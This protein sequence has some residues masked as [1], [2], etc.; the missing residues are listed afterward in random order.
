MKMLISYGLLAGFFVLVVAV[1]ERTCKREQNFTDYAVAGRSFGP[2]FQTM[3]FLN[4]W[5]PGTIFIAFAGMAASSGVIGYYLIAYSLLALLLM[6][7]MAE[8]VFNW[9]TRFNLR[10]QADLVGMRY[11]ARSVRLIAA[12]IGIVSSFPWL[13]LGFQSL[14]LVF[15]YLSFGQVSVVG[16]IFIGIG[17]LAV[18]QIWTVRFGMRG[19]VISDMVQGLFAYV[20]G[21]LIALG[22]LVKLWLSGHDLNRLP[23]SLFS[24][25]G[26]GSELGPLYYMSI[27]LTGALGAW[28]WPDIFV[29]LFT[30][31]SV[32][33]IQQSVVRSAPLLYVFA[34]ILLSMAL[35]ANSVP[36]VA[37][38]P[39]QVWF[40]LASGA[41]VM[42][43]SLAGIAVLAAT[44]GNINAG[45]SAVGIQLTQDI[46]F[47]NK[48]VSDWQVTRVAKLAIAVV[49]A[50]GMSGALLTVNM[51]SGLI[52]LAL[53]SYQGIV[54]LA[55]ALY[56][57]LFW[58]R[59]NAAGAV[60]GMVS[61]FVAAA[62]LQ[63]YYPVSI[64]ALWG[65]SSGMVGMMI[66]SVVYI[67]LAYALPVSRQEAER[68][69]L[70]FSRLQ[71][72]ETRLADETAAT[73]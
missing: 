55:P 33:T 29:R 50:L 22:L 5:L 62:V 31:N 46:I 41:G 53:I 54:Q 7:Y 63:W 49:A 16:G 39:D 57:G 14:G 36:A 70:L 65:L 13:V 20:G 72:D 10:T 60:G 52:T 11:N 3:A 64:G 28:C 66:N 42:V 9:G 71:T 12:V 35:L 59:G 8:R 47:L 2:W 23:A 43:L 58:R 18:R 21:A 32:R 67:A 61:G 34:F 1:L 6:F 30:A 37:Q 17:V 45:T 40:I 44:M 48:R 38:L 19:I 15:S 69:A 56:L 27:V 51:S 68:V 26:W 24:L 73:A 25:P 4:T